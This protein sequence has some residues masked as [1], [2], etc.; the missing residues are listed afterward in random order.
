MEVAEAGLA[1][2]YEALRE[3]AF[4]RRSGDRHGLA[5][6]LRDGMAAWLAA[7]SACSLTPPIDA[8]AISSS[9]DLSTPSVDTLVALLASM[10]LSTLQTQ[11][12]PS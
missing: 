5:L 12:Q 2:R 4:A 7:W 8:A 3:N 9:K 1:G 11:E 6:F 10:A